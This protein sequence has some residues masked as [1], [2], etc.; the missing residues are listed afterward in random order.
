MADRFS[1]LLA[2]GKDG[3]LSHKEIV[4]LARFLNAPLLDPLKDPPSGF[5]SK[6]RM[7]ESNVAGRIEAIE[8]FVHCGEPHNFDLTMEVERVK[9]WPQAMKAC[10]SRSWEYATLEARNQLTLALH[11]RDRGRDRDWNEITLKF[12]RELAMPFTEKVWEPFRQ[13]HGLSVEFVHCIQWDI[14]AAMMENAY[15]SSKHRSFFFL[16]LLTVYEAGHLPCG[17]RGKWP[18]GRLVVY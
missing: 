14:L 10:R 15:I 18:L 11:N 4:E 3:H 6:H 5:V 7:S 17:W 12:K 1:E 13:S 8:W 9:T 2:R 16:E